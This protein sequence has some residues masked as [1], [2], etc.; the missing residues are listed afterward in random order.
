MKQTNE[1]L[2]QLKKEIQSFFDEGTVTIVGSGLSCSEG[3]SGMGSLAKKLIKEVPSKI[4]EHNIKCWEVVEKSLKNGIDLETALQENNINK[5]IERTII[6]IT[7]DLISAEDE[8]IFREILEQGRELKFSKFLSYFNTNLYNL[9]IIT[10]NYD[11]LIEYAFEINELPYFDSYTGNIIS[12]NLGKDYSSRY[13][14]QKIQMKKINSSRII[15]LFKPHGSIN[16][17]LINGKYFKINNIDCG[18]PCIITPG[19]NKYERGYNIP[20]D[21][22]ISKMS[23]EIDKSKRM[24]FIGYGFNDNHLE[25]HLKK[26]ENINKPK[27]IITRSLSDNAKKLIEDSPDIIAIEKD[28]DFSENKGTRVYFNNENYLIEDKNLWDIEELVKEVFNE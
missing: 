22:H 11:L 21:Y 4:K 27:L 28:K 6:N 3:I 15:K 24:I 23:E 2:H 9:V 20:F 14:K 7:Y 26:S 10:T 13:L 19:S 18:E 12:R 17:K 25:T 16:W 8:K 5:E 1:F